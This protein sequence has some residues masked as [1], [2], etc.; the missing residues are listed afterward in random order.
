[1]T[2]ILLTG[3][4]AELSIAELE[5]LY[6]SAALRRIGDHALVDAEVDFDR[7][8]GSIKMA[9]LL[10]VLETANPQKTFDYCRKAL[11]D[12]VANFPEGK[13]KLGIS[14]YGLNMPIHKQNA[15]ALT[16]KKAIKQSGRSVRAVPNTE[17]ALSSAQT[18]HNRLTSPLGL[19][20][21]FVA[22][23]GKTYIGRVTNV[24]DI[25][26]Y[27]MRDRGRPKRDAFVG[28]LPPKL[29][30]TIVNLAA[31]KNQSHESRVKSQENTI[32]LQQGNMTIFDPFCG[33]GVILQE[34]ALMG[35]DVCGT[36]MSPKMIDYSTAN[37]EWL[38]QKYEIKNIKYEIEQADATNHNWRNLSDRS[39]AIATE[40]YLGQPIGGQHPTQEKMHD[41]IHECNFIMRGFLRNI[42][43]Q[44][45]SG[46]HLCIAA[47][48]WHIDGIYHNLPVLDD[49]TSLGF[50]QVSFVHTNA[51]QLVYSR[52]DQLTHRRLLV[53]TRS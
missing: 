28:M 19:E 2:H 16:L 41:I 44:L 47:P 35:Y 38:T 53:L 45:P 36:D 14:L 10:T 30:Q 40:S 17:A 43:A 13:I 3:R 24:Q 27:T 33:T 31:G 11:P 39:V 22:A 48:S 49:L 29:A 51:S 46:T 34:A 52:E 1:M 26:S 21:V 25:D 4:L 9:S 23:G 7:L 8:G 32:K 50:N 42:A 6:G 12:F 5:S 20:L 15:N 18:F 37:L